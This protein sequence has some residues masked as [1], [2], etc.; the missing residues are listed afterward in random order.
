MWDGGDFCAN[1]PQRSFTVELECGTE[2]KAWGASEP[3]TCVYTAKMSTPIA[4]DEEGLAAVQG[5]LQ[6]LLDE[7]AAIAREIAEAEA[8]KAAGAPQDPRDEL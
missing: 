2:T 3:S 4:C 6:K 5:E 8:A 7:E 1:A